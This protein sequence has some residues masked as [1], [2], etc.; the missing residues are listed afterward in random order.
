MD[1]CDV[2]ADAWNA[3]DGYVS[4]VDGAAGADAAAAGGDAGDADGGSDRRTWVVWVAAL[5]VCH[6]NVRIGKVGGCARRH[7]VANVIRFR[8]ALTLETGV[9]KVVNNRQANRETD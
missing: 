9:N 6:G 5:G 4:V 1:N 2:G 8:F 7:D 3:L